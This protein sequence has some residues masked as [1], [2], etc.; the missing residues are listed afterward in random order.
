MNYA[1]QNVQYRQ[2]YMTLAW[3]RAEDR[4]EAKEEGI[5]EGERNAKLEAARNLLAMKLLTEEQIAEA[6][7]LPLEEV[8]QL[9]SESSNR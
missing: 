6:Q 8:Q 5:A 3:I 2:G 9:A 4:R 7:G 1:R